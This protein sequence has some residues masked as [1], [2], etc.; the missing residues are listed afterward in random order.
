MTLAMCVNNLIFSFFDL[1]SIWKFI[2][3]TLLYISVTLNER[4]FSGG[5]LGMK[6]INLCSCNNSSWI[7]TIFFLHH[8]HLHV[9]ADTF[10]YLFKNTASSEGY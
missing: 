7:F 9:I 8:R 1:I 10:S 6:K 5:G 4:I 3:Y 2:I